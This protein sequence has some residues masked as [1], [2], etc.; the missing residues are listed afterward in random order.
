[1]I[2][3]FKKFISRGNVLDLA[4]G[5]IIGGAF[6]KIVASVV[7]DLLMPLIGSLLGGFDFTN[8]SFKIGDAVIK[9]GSFIQNVFNFLFIALALFLIIKFINKLQKPKQD[10]K[11]TKAPVVKPDD[12]L[13][14][15]EIRDLL[16]KQN[17]K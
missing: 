1:M 4:V 10:E 12:V 17:K 13:L 7:D 16:K 11:E 2:K 9:Y 6:S 3:E 14:L 15:E 8:L 5:V